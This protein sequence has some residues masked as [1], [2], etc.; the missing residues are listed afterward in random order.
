M[1]YVSDAEKGLSLDERRFGT[2]SVVISQDMPHRIAVAHVLLNV[3][4]GAGTVPRIATEVNS[5]E[6]VDE[7]AGSL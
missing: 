5:L 7:V 4:N 6:L 3:L 2:A 1:T